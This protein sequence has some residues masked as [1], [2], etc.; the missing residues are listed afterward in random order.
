MRYAEFKSTLLPFMGTVR[1]PMGSR[2]LTIKMVLICDGYQ[3][4]KALYSHL[5]GSEH[6]V[7]VVQTMNESESNRLQSPEELQV[8]AMSD[9]AKKIRLRAKTL[10]AKK[11]LDKANQSLQKASG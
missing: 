4:A 3:Q 11:S 1:I 10:Q 6:V 9:Q 8:K 7:S 2:L 5:F